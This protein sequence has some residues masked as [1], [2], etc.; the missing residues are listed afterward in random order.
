MLLKG[1]FTVVADLGHITSLVPVVTPDDG[2]L[3]S[4]FCCLTNNSMMDRRHAIAALTRKYGRTRNEIYA[5]IERAK[6]SG[7]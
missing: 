7:V 2:E 4:E 5:V 1:E 3:V 6:K